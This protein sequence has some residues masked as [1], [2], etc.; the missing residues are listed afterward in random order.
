MRL[1]IEV[2]KIKTYTMNTLIPQQR[3][4]NLRFLFQKNLELLKLDGIIV[5]HRQL[6]ESLGELNEN[7]AYYVVPFSRNIIRKKKGNFYSMIFYYN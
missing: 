1:N 3:I 6:P 2:H 5:S 7:Y 4:T